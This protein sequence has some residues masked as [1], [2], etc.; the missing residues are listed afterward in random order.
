MPPKPI[1]NSNL[2]LAGVKVVE[3]SGKWPYTLSLCSNLDA[4]V[5]T[6]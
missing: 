2:P 5:N 3:V 4:D 1:V 6:S